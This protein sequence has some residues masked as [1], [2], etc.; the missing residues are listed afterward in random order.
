[1]PT[2]KVTRFSRLAATSLKGSMRL[3]MLGP[4]SLIGKDSPKKLLEDLH[5]ATAEDLLETLGRLK[6][7]SMKLGQ[8]ASFIDA[9]VLPPDVRDLY[10][11]V[12]GSL[13][14]AAPPMKR[15]LVT[16]VFRHEFG[17][18]PG[19][20]FARF[21]EEPVAAASL[22]QVHLALTKDGREVAVKVQ[23]PGIED[24]I[25]SDLAVTTAVR[26]LLPLLA[27]GLDAGDALEEMRARLLEECDYLLEAENMDTLAD[28]Y[29]GHP[30]VIVPRSIPE[31]STERILT[32]GRARGRPFAKVMELGQ[33]EKDRVGE[34]LFRFY[35][36]SLYRYGFTSADPHPG[37]YFLMDDG[38]M[39]FFDFGLACNLD[40]RM[41][42][43]LQGAFMALRDQDVQG[44]FK[45]AVAMRYVTR[46]DQIDPRRF[47]DWVRLVLDPVSEDRE[48]TFT[49]EFIA[50]RTATMLDPR[51]PWWSFLRQLNLPRWGILVYRLELGLFA[52]LAQLGAT[53]NWHRIVL[54]FWNVAEPSTELGRAEAEWMTTHP[55]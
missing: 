13:R 52:V 6:G 51:N 16:E 34:M 55:K 35:Y 27:P 3:A 45:N 25:R 1:M 38:R 10:Q 24:A 19:D 37:N 36:G 20:I 11:G 49:R 23:Y 9:G 12:L 50:E 28:R 39:A 41:V 4:R 31:L 8:L 54:E 43:F 30:F 47:Y 29:E 32:M 46:P 5:L 2:G 15:E 40:P 42:P 7:T 26:P 53:A 17:K 21:S 33:A 18:D 48:Y 14:D 22:G 44:V